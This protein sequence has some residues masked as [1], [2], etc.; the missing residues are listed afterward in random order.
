[1]AIFDKKNTKIEDSV[2]EDGEEAPRPLDPKKHARKQARTA[3]LSALKELVDRQPDKKYQVALA[4]IRPS[5]YGIAVG[6]GSSRSKFLEYVESKKTVDE[7]EIFKV[8]KY[9]RKDCAGYIRK[10]LKDAVPAERLWI[11]FNAQA[12]IYKFEGKGKD[13]PK[14]WNGY[15]PVDEVIALSGTLK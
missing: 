13:A 2:E 15:L 3:A 11:S 6:T 5:L 10:G 1:M 12:G 8:F 4:T 9:G 14:G 7:D